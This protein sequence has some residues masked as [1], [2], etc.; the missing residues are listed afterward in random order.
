M[1]MDKTTSLIEYAII[2]NMLNKRKKQIN[3]TF[4]FKTTITHYF[5]KIFFLIII[6]QFKHK[7]IM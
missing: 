2:K 5:H 6:I 7:N 4:I 1:L 3:I